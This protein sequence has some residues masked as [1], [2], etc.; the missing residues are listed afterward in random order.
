MAETDDYPSTPRWSSLSGFLALVINHANTKLSKPAA[1]QLILDFYAEVR[2]RRRYYYQ[3]DI[4]LDV[5]INLRKPRK[6]RFVAIDPRHWRGPAGARSGNTHVRVDWKNSRVGPDDPRYEMRLVRLYTG[7]AFAVL[8]WARLWE[9]PADA[10]AAPAS[11]SPSPTPPQSQSEPSPNPQWATL[12]GW[13]KQAL[14]DHPPEE[15]QRKS[16]YA[17]ALLK[18]VP[19]SEKWTEGGIANELTELGKVGRLPKSLMRKSLSSKVS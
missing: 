3:T 17:R 4:T 11:S 14:K 15:W 6:L 5:D 12:K 19:E 2:P 13:V 18:L 7:D 16:E 9:P 1:K 10:S 8:R